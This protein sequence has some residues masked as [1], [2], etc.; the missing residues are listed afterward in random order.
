MNQLI[1]ANAEDYLDEPLFES[2]E[3]PQWVLTKLKPVHLSICSLVAQ[4]N[5]YVDIAKM[6]GVTPQYITMLMRQ[7]I[8]KDEVVRK[9]ELVG[10]RLELLFEKSVDTI[11]DAME[12]GNHKEKLQAAR[13]QLEATRRIGRIDPFALTGNVPSDRLENLAKRLEGLLD[14]TKGGLYDEAG[15]PL[16][17][18][19]EIIRTKSD[20]GRSEGSE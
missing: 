14:K 3:K 20:S 16:F 19:A 2:E 4:G 10:T 11:V 15:N 6:V 1:L 9:A 17:E 13:L 18:E 7:Q 8:I 12:N 5:K